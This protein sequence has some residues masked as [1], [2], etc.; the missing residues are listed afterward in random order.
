MTTLKRAFSIEIPRE[1]D[2]A[3][4]FDAL[5]GT[6]HVHVQPALSARG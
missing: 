5:P 6:V 2:P 3:K 1:N 4:G